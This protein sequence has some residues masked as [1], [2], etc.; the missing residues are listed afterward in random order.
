MIL[1]LV[2]LGLAAE[3]RLEPEKLPTSVKDAVHARYADATITAAS[4]EGRAYEAT[5][6]LGTRTMDLAFSADGTWLEEEEVVGA[7][8]LPEPVRTAIEGRWKG[9][10]IVRAERAITPKSTSYEVLIRSGEQ[11]AEAVLGEDGSVKRVEMG[12]EEE[13]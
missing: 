12:E 6:T 3:H 13:D 1:F 8:L 5:I 2:T 10:S 11:S 4:R 9:W 7:D